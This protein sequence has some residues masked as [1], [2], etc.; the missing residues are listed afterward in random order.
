MDGVVVRSFFNPA[1]GHHWA[2]FLVTTDKGHDAIRKGWK[3]S[4][5]YDIRNKID[6]QDKWHGAEYN[7]EILDAVYNHLAIVPNPR[8]SESVILT[9][10]Q[11]KEYNNK[12]EADQRRKNSLEG[13]K[14]KLNLF[15]RTKVENSE[16]LSEVSVKLP[17]SGKEM[18]LQ[19]V[20]NSLDERLEKEGKPSEVKDED[21]IKVGKETITIADF[22]KRYE[23]ACKKNEEMEEESKENED[24]EEE[25]E[26]MDEEDRENEDEEERENEEVVH[27]KSDEKKLN[28]K[29][30]NSLDDS[31][32][33][34]NIDSLKNARENAAQSEQKVLNV[35]S[36]FVNKGKSLFGSGK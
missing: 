10:D 2:E 20:V 4:N 1:D 18:T 23:N 7:E 34:K 35:G 36:D 21:T 32:K 5:A 3:L 24:E 31:T 16:E 11:F 30:K 15:K 6:V 13:D 19:T 26:N 12:L 22:K 28:G 33:K 8:Y 9:P 29:K 25:K 14:M 27:P 17:K